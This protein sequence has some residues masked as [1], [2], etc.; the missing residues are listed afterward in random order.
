MEMS[1]RYNFLIDVHSIH[2]KLSPKYGLNLCFSRRFPYTDA[3]SF[4]HY[5]PLHIVH[6][7]K[8]G[9]MPIFRD[10]LLRSPIDK[11]LREKVSGCVSRQMRAEED[12]SR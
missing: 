7:W 10:F 3:Q 2:N 1:I 4:S 11:N 6:F 9:N 12:F 8:V 5:K